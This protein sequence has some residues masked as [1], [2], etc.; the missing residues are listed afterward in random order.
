MKLCNAI[1]Y[2]ELR[3]LGY[4]GVEAPTLPKALRWISKNFQIGYITS[5]A[6]YAGECWPMY[7]IDRRTGET[8]LGEICDSRAEA[9]E[10]AVNSAVN[11]IIM[12]KREK[13]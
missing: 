9:L 3:E 13:A 8:I 12:S 4:D 7:L 1:I 5:K 10:A 6:Y 2:K 11:F